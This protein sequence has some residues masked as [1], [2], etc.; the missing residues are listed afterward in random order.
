MLLGKLEM[1]KKLNW[2]SF[3]YYSKINLQWVKDFNIRS[4]VA[5]PKRKQR[6]SSLTGIWA[7]IIF[8]DMTSKA[9]ATKKKF[10]N[11]DYIKQKVFCT[12]KG[13]INKMKAT[14]GM[15]KIYATHIL[16]KRLISKIYKE[17]TSL[18]DDDNS[19]RQLN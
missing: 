2:T 13:P 4:D 18:N 6:R 5:I 7:I 19:N 1:Q 12:A 8:F 14:Y 11:W 3:L 9:Q 15:E 17:L 10:N 16:E